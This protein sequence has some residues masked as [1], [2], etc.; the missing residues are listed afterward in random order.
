MK[1]SGIIA[2]GELIQLTEAEILRVPNLG[3]LTINLIKAE[4]SQLDLLLGSIRKKPILEESA[5]AR[6]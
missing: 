5:H 6:L 4:L 1:K 2:V 3:R